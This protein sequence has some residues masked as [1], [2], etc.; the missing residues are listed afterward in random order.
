[1][2]S[3]NFFAKHCWPKK[4]ASNCSSSAHSFYFHQFAHVGSTYRMGRLS[5]MDQESDFSKK[6]ALLGYKILEVECPFPAKVLAAKRPI[7]WNLA[8]GL[9]RGLSLH[10]SRTYMHKLALGS[11]RLNAVKVNYS[12][13]LGVFPNLLI[14]DYGASGDGKSPGLWL[15]TQVMHY[16]RKKIL[17]VKVKAWQEAKDAYDNWDPK[18][19]E[20]RP[21]EPGNKPVW[22]ELYDGGSTGG[23]GQQMSENGGRAFLI[24]HEGRK[25]VYGLLQGGPAGSMDDLNALAEHVFAKNNPLNNQSKFRVENPHLVA[26]ILMHLEE[27]V[28][29]FEK[30]Q[31][32]V[33]G[34]Q[35]F[36]YGHLPAVVNKIHVDGDDAADGDEWYFNDVSFDNAILSLVNPLLIMDKL[37]EEDKKRSDETDGMYS[38]LSGIHIMSWSAEAKKKSSR[39]SIPW[40]TRSAPHSRIWVQRLTLA[41]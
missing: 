35:R 36:R 23:L 39:T 15:D 16:L 12:G 13:I 37:Y 9:G 34:L 18:S 27:S 38:A 21:P 26:Y 41:S 2:R 33:A 32:S 11:L 5:K 3:I 28:P 10:P 29:L 30:D 20:K 7:S 31:D 6:D 17:A 24:K 19:K 1:M 4:V 8:V 25:Y 22:D 40:S 14:I